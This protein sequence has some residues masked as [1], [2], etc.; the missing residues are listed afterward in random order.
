MDVTG[1]KNGRGA[2]LCHKEEC[3]RKAAKN[4]GLERSFRMKVDE[5][6]LHSLLEQIRNE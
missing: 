2:Y 6:T 4:R 3:L 5:E 1:K